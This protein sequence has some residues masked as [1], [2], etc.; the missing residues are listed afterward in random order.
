M[1]KV[2]KNDV[3]SRLDKI[4]LK[5][6][7]KAILQLQTDEV[8][9]VTPL[10]DGGLRSSITTELATSKNKVA[11]IISRGNIAPYNIKVHE[12]IEPVNWTEP[13]TGSKYIENPVKNYSEKYIKKAIREGLKKN[14]F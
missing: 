5:E 11:K 14:G 4:V 8:I 1:Y 6:F 13:G 10:R 12:L 7:N 9:P 2:L 3:L